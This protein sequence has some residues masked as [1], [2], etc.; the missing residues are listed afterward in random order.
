[1]PNYHLFKVKFLPFTAKNN[2]TTRISIKSERFKEKVII[3]TPETEQHKHTFEHAEEY[4]KSKGFNIIGHGET[5][6]G[7][8]VI[9]DTFEPLK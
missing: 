8:I 5:D 1:M 3:D 6:E 4:L 7:Y 2:K 9:S